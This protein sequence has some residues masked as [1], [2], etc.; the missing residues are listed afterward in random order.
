M[1]SINI[2]FDNNII[3]TTQLLYEMTNIESLNVVRD[4]GLK[5]SNFLVWTGL[6]HSV[7]LRLRVH[8]P[9][10]ENILDLENCK[11]RDYYHLLIKQKYEKPNKSAKLREEF[12]LEDKQLSEAFVMPLRV[13]NEPY[14]RSFQYKVLNSILYT[15]ELLCKIGYVSDP[16]CSFCHQTIETISHIFFDCS[17]STSFW[18]EICGKILNKLSSR[19]CL[20]LE[21][22]EIILGFLTGK[23]DLT[24]Y[25]LILGKAYLWTCRCKETK[26]SFS[27]FERILL[28]KYQTEKYISFQSDNINLFKKKWR[29]FEERV[30]FK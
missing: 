25:I 29:I 1:S 7:P 30:F 16:N 11:C 23:M 12:N 17:F 27:H 18:N 19:G 3:Y 13:A 4:A 5:T 26:P 8:V 28:N 24:N 14:L 10:F 21:Y 6:R 15:N 2:F 9:N 22:R 20:S